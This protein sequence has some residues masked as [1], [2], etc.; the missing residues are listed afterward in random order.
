MFFTALFGAY[1]IFRMA[2]PPGDWPSRQDVHVDV[3]LGAL[4]TAILLAS[5]IAIGFAV[6]CAKQNRAS[7]AKNWL[8]MTI[9]LGVAFLA[10]KSFEYREKIVRG[11][12]P[13]APRSLLHDRADIYYLSHLKEVIARETLTAAPATP[14]TP[15]KVEPI[16]T[17]G[18][19]PLPKNPARLV[20][21]G[22]V[23]WTETAISR[24]TDEQKKLELIQLAADC[25][26]PLHNSR[27]HSTELAQER[28][29]LLEQMTQL[30]RTKTVQ[31]TE[32][33]TIQSELKKLNADAG[34]SNL[35]PEQKVAS[36][37]QARLKVNLLAKLT[38]DFTTSKL[39]SDLIRD[40]VD[41]ID[42]ALP[43]L[44]A[45]LG[46]KINLRLPIVILNGQTWTS[47]YFLLTGFHALHLVAG[48][49]VMML[50]FPMALGI[51]RA[52]LLENV[53]PPAGNS[54]SA[55]QYR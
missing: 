31:Q 5:S 36:A 22:L 23:V 42:F 50:L 9:A 16:K 29:Q 49:V 1:L 15:K 54:S 41:F 27:S 33:T 19:K 11:I 52:G 25:V 37:S 8:A 28:D 2:V 3:W 21:A 55:D 45:G 30:E 43:D 4:N 46:T 26:Q 14:V 12:Y 39:E 24:T 53:A 47:T 38:L 48:I 20:A 35:N 44:D 32:L 40:R 7:A 51:A 13:A 10:V 6:T 17:D 18:T 34:S